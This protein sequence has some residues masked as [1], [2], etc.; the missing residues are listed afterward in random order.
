MLLDGNQMRFRKISTL[1]G[2][3][4]M[5]RI[6][7]GR[8]TVASAVGVTLAAMATTGISDMRAAA[9]E[10]EGS[11]N[12]GVSATLGKFSSSGKVRI[13]QRGNKETVERGGL[14]ELSIGSSGM[15]FV[16]CIDLQAD[17]QQGVAYQE[18]K[19]SEA[20]K[21]K[22]N[23]DAQKVNWI[24]HHSF[25]EIDTDALGEVTGV[26]LSKDDAAAGTQAAIWQ[27]TD[28][29]DAVP[30]APAAAK[31]TEYLMEQVGRIE[32]PRPTLALNPGTIA[33][34]VGKTLGPVAVSTVGEAVEAS[35]DPVSAKA[36]V[37]LT[38]SAG[39]VVSD[40]E[41]RLVHPARHGDQ[42]YVKPPDTRSDSATITASA[43]LELPVG[44]AF[45]S[46][47]SQSVILAGTA[48]VHTTT[49]A[50]VTW[51]AS[52][53]TASPTRGSGDPSQSGGPEKPGDGGGPAATAAPNSSNSWDKQGNSKNRLGSSASPGQATSH[54]SAQTG[55]ET[56]PVVSDQLP[57][58]GGGIA[59]QL[60]ATAAVLTCLG[61]ALAL[62]ARHRRRRH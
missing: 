60:A 40:V 7:P 2:R 53:P 28:H 26:K 17:A 42:V 20:P 3:E 49:A 32:E 48:E 55:E 47:G 18:N 10:P 25:P 39:N 11:S 50:R 46:P 1:A 44:R 4:R 38:D 5:A 33:G 12:S 29:V 8:R 23:P 13:T 22:G 16:Y 62:L 58:T 27:L 52:R 43:S 15:A 57:D 45:T 56:G 21:L 41:G 24:L 9:V 19:W 6:I 31:L 14:F 37:V 59:Y 35:L 34:E 51:T 36:G 30:V 54:P 61:V